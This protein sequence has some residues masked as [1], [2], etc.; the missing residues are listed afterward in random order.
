MDCRKGTNVFFFPQSYDWVNI[1][2]LFLMHDHK[3]SQQFLGL[4]ERVGEG[5]MTPWLHYHTCYIIHYNWPK[6]E[7]ESVFTVSSQP[8]PPIHIHRFYCAFQLAFSGI[9]KTKP[10]FTYFSDNQL[11]SQD[12]H[13]E[14]RQ[15]PSLSFYLPKLRTV[16]N[17]KPSEATYHQCNSNIKLQLHMVIDIRRIQLKQTGEQPKP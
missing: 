7:H 8:L 11:I 6:H 14:P 3:W 16:L 15:D 13:L 12:L 2:G 9:S 1:V 10:S 5:P 4:L 17:Q